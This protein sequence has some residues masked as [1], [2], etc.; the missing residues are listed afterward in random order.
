[1][2]NYTPASLGLARGLAQALFLSLLATTV[3]AA[4][5]SQG[6]D[7]V[8]NPTCPRSGKP[9]VEDSTTWYRGQRVGFC[10]PHCR[11]DFV[12]NVAARPDDRVF[13]DTL[14]DPSPRVPV[15]EDPSRQFDFWLGRWEVT[16]RFL[17]KDGSWRVGGVAIAEIDSV[18]GGK[19]IL[20]RWTGQ[21]SLA[22]RGMSLRTYDAEESRWE[23]ILNWPSGTPSGFS[24][25]V[26]NF[27]DGRGELFPPT[28][29]PRTRFTFS[30]AREQSCQWDQST[31][32]DGVTWTT[33]WIMDFRR[34][35]PARAVTADNLEISMPAPGLANRYPECRQLDR[36]IGRWKTARPS[37][38]EAVRAVSAVVDGL[39]LLQMT[40]YADGYEAIDVLAFSP[41]QQLWHSVGMSSAEPDCHWLAGA[42]TAGKIEF[43]E[44]P[45]SN[46]RVRQYGTRGA[47]GEIDY[48]SIVDGVSRTNRFYGTSQIREIPHWS[49]GIPSQLA[50]IQALLG[51]KQ[52]DPAE[53]LLRN[54]LSANPEHARATFLLGYTLHLRGKHNEAERAYLRAEKMPATQMMAR[55]NLACLCA[56]RKDVDRAFG[57]LE[58]MKAGGYSNWAQV[59][60]DPDFDLLRSDSRFEAYLPN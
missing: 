45:R 24:M 17:Q 56:V 4:T 29:S 12:A 27:K 1:M 19:A 13:F 9:V 14:I 33:N 42:I 18:L 10:N 50:T 5:G 31:S 22:M 23:V 35:G 55:Y 41:N 28:P 43:S 11:D 48:Q 15:P 59:A 49:P 51:L 32:A 52:A 46:N 21:G 8:L 38:G 47:P 36:W 16:N 7:V 34:V 6:S 3:H 39:A 20:E 2:K 30:E 53:A 40:K 54:V 44:Q 37:D 25:V 57:Y 60:S 26:G 58:A